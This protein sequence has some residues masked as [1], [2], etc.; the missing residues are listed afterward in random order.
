MAQ[1]YGLTF[2]LAGIETASDVVRAKEYGILLG[3][4]NFFA[5]PTMPQLR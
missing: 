4:G 2:T 5:R 3:Q 1:E